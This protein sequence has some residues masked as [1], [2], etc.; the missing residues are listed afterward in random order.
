MY[1]NTILRKRKKYMYLLYLHFVF[2]IS[3]Y[4]V[5]CGSFILQ[6]RLT[7]ASFSLK[8]YG[9]YYSN[10]G[11]SCF[12]Q[13]SHLINFRNKYF[14][15]DFYAIVVKIV[16]IRLGNGWILWTFWNRNHSFLVEQ[17]VMIPMKQYPHSSRSTHRQSKLTINLIWLYYLSNHIP[18]CRQ[19]PMNW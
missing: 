10:E 9:L 14:F 16:T 18:C 12:I 13:S 5:S 19:C 4:G 15:I 2:F 8:P 17:K 7:S 1:C 6:I 3:S 11:Y